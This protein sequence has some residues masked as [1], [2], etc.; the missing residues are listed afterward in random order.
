MRIRNSNSAFEITSME[1]FNGL[2]ILTLVEVKH[3]R[4]SEHLYPN[5][6]FIVISM[7]ELKMCYKK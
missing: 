2:E 6:D 3:D 7:Q 4:I 1:V 5:S